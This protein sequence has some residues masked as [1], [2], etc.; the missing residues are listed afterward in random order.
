MKLLSHVR[1]FA[2]P[3]TVACQAPPSLGFSMQGY[4]SGLPFP[5]LCVLPNPGIKPESPTLQ[6]DWAT[7]EAQMTCLVSCNLDVRAFCWWRPLLQLQLCESQSWNS[8]FWAL[9]AE[10]VWKARS[11]LLV[12]LKPGYRSFQS[13]IPALSYS[14]FSPTLLTVNPAI[15]GISCAKEI[16]ITTVYT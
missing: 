3:W 2:T 7:R 8:W 9:P 14:K 5:S 12:P 10:E 15:P 6:A 16:L 4:W 11:W 13:H 1:F